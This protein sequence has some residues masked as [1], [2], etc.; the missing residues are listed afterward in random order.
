M[1]QYLRSR[2]SFEEKNVIQTK[3]PIRGY[4]MSEKLV[5][6]QKFHN[7]SLSFCHLSNNII[8]TV[9]RSSFLSKTPHVLVMV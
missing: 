5:L 4:V 2:Q 1:K 9:G 7:V 6:F 3:T 8:H